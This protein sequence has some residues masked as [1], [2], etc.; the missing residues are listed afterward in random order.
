MVGKLLYHNKQH[1]KILINIKTCLIRKQET[2]VEQA[3]FLATTPGP[4]KENKQN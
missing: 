4:T 3:S 2:V 1:I